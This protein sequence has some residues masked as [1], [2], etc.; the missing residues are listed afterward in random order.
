MVLVWKMD[1][2]CTRKFFRRVVRALR[3]T[4]CKF[5]KK[6][7]DIKRSFF[8]TKKQGIILPPK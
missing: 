6:T 3:Y 4:V 1:L 8:L 2:S 5:A 7:A